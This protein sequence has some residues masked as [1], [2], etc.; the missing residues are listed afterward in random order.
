M[1]LDEQN[2][3]PDE[4]KV[5]ARVLVQLG[6]EL[7]TDAEQAILECVKNAYDAD[8]LGCKVVIRTKAYGS[9]DQD[10][11]VCCPANKWHK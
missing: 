3:R 10:E 4:I 9:F 1:G 8:S 6:E 7:V 11:L 5:S 2:H